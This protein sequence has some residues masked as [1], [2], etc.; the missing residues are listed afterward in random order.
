MGVNSLMAKHFNNIRL[1]MN[2]VYCIR[3]K[4]CYKI[5]QHV[6]L[7]L[8]NTTNI[9]HEAQQPYNYLIESIRIRDSENKTLREH[10]RLLEEDLR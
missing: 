3:S 9:L 4:V 7:Q 10:N 5:L 1:S 6:F 8:T 2:T